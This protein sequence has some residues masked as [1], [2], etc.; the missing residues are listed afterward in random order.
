MIELSPPR[1]SRPHECP[2]LRQPIEGA[3]VVPRHLSERV[4]GFR[5]KRQREGTITGVYDGSR[6]GGR[7]FQHHVC[8]RPAKTKRTRCGSP[9]LRASFPG[10][11]SRRD[12]WKQ[13][14]GGNFRI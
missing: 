14:I 9:P 2:H 3:L 8:I 13:G 11:E 7:F 5:R 12:K 4:R 6:R 1:A 10:F